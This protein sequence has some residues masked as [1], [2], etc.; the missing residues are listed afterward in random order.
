MKRRGLVVGLCCGV[1]LAAVVAWI[2]GA[3]AAGIVG[4]IVGGIV[5][6]IVHQVQ[7]IRGKPA[8]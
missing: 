2:V 1:M 7:K 4:L 3:I 6:L 8:H 5:V